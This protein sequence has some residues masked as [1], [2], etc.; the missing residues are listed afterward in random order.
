MRTGQS[1]TSQRWPVLCFTLSF[2]CPDVPP[3]SGHW[4]AQ[5]SPAVAA[6]AAHCPTSRRTS[7]LLCVWPRE[8]HKLLCKLY[9]KT[10]SISLFGSCWL[11]LLLL[12]SSV[13]STFF[14]PALIGFFFVFWYIFRL[15]PPSCPWFI[16]YITLPSPIHFLLC[17]H[18]HLCS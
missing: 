1:P 10:T 11:C 6:R 3:P 9:Q 7:L 15:S 14:F 2:S 4:P 16:C 18:P 17:L 12:V 5:P 13:I 8:A